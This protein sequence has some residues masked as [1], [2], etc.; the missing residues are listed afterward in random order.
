MK[1]RIKPQQIYQLQIMFTMSLL[2]L[3][4]AHLLK[5]LTDKRGSSVTVSGLKPTWVP[6]SCILSLHSAA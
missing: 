4:Q 5:N 1:I 6:C 3:Q 2:A